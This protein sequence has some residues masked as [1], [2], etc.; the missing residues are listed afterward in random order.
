MHKSPKDA[1]GCGRSTFYN[2]SYEKQCTYH[3][4][5]INRCFRCIFVYRAS[6]SESELHGDCSAAG[7]GGAGRGGAGCRDVC[8]GVRGSS[9][10]GYRC[11]TPAAEIR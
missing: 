1:H 9:E 11:G 7:Q 6:L 3:S 5:E 8:V 2:Q 4:Y 10:R